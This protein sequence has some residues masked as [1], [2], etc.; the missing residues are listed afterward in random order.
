M[1]VPAKP[2]NIRG[3]A[4]G[5]SHPARSLAAVGFPI[6]RSRKNVPSQ[7]DPRVQRHISHPRILQGLSG[8]NR[9]KP[10]LVPNSHLPRD[11]PPPPSIP[12]LSYS[13]SHSHSLSPPTLLTQVWKNLPIPSPPPK[14]NIQRTTSPAPWTI[15]V[16]RVIS[17]IQN[18]T[19]GPTSL[20]IDSVA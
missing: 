19:T 4:C 12:H 17:K 1:I 14:R 5:R 16:H 9:A 18:P 3:S 10:S 6:P 7:D 2:V 11:T 13:P 20:H 8:E 15:C